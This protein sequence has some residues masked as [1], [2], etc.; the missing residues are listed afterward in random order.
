MEA[1]GQENWNGHKRPET[2]SEKQ[3]FLR[4]RIYG[5][6]MFTTVGAS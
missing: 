5:F 4:M 1:L 2:Y 3:H 6:A